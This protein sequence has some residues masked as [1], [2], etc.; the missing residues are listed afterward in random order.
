MFHPPTAF[1]HD[2]CRL[3]RGLARPVLPAAT[4]A[5]LAALAHG[6]PEAAWSGLTDR[7]GGGRVAGWFLANADAVAVPLPTTARKALERHAAADLRRSLNT[8]RLLSR[9][10]PALLAG[11]RPDCLVLKGVGVER[12][13]YPTTIVRHSVDIDLLPRPDAVARTYAALRDLGLQQTYLSRSHHVRTMS[14]PVGGGAVEVHEQP[15]CPYRFAPMR[16][17]ALVEALFDRSV[18]IRGGIAAGTA[19]T[20]AD[21][22]HTAYLLAHLGEGVFAE[23]RHLADLCLWL[24]VVQPDPAAVHARLVEWQAVRAGAAALAA[25][26]GFDGLAMTPELVHTLAELRKQTGPQQWLGDALRLAATHALRLPSGKAPR[27]LGG[28]GLAAHLDRPWRWAASWTPAAGWLRAAATTSKV[29]G[30][31]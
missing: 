31:G 4:G 18:E 10:A 2:A 19:R 29:Q 23:Q 13:A 25:V 3:L 28:L 16:S 17:S 27:W 20:L 6:L 7:L 30:H 22:D 9:L 24:R 21:V 14:E 12:R 5:D 11:A 1:S 26:A 8:Q 15:L